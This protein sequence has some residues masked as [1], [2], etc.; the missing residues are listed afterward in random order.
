MKAVDF[1]DLD[2]LTL[3]GIAYNPIGCFGKSFKI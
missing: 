1:D 2:C 3:E